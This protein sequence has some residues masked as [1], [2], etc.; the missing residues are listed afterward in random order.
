VHAGMVGYDGEK[1]SKS[2]GN[3]VLVSR[4]REAGVDPMAIRLALLAHH[5][6][7]DWEWTDTELDRAHRRLAAWR[8]AVGAASRTQ[9]EALVAAVRTALADD[10]DAPA[11]LAAVDVWAAAAPGDGSGADL[12]RDLLDARLG[13]LL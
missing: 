12:V 3:L 11:A 9:A 8:E 13:I 6:R 5:Y 4:L 7:C 2:R 1:M 10:L